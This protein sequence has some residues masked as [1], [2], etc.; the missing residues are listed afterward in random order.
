MKRINV[1][2]YDYKQDFLF[3]LLQRRAFNL[4]YGSNRIMSFFI[5]IERVYKRTSQCLLK[6]GEK[7]KNDDEKIELVKLTNSLNAC[8]TRFEL[9]HIVEK[10]LDHSRSLLRS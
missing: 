8:S 7:T 9:A 3:E 10:A 2:E 6:L 4:Q 5:D 1:S